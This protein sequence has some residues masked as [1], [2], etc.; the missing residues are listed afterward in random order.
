[1]T[2]VVRRQFQSPDEQTEPM[3][4]LKLVLLTVIGLYVFRKSCDTFLAIMGICIGDAF[5]RTQ[6]DSLTRMVSIGFLVQ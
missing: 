3:T 5:V 2:I 1:M 4:T 6:G